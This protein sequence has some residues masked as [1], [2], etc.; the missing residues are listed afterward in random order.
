[1]PTNTTIPATVDTIR[2]SPIGSRNLHKGAGFFTTGGGA[3]AYDTRAAGTATVVDPRGMTVPT[4]TR[5]RTAAGM[6]GV[7][8]FGFGSEGDRGAAEV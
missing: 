1:M 7:P 3:G 6:M 8:S 4:T 2:A 5:E